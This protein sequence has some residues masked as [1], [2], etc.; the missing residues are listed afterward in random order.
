MSVWQIINEELMIMD[1]RPK[2]NARANMMAGKGYERG[3]QYRSVF[4]ALPT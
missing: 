1:C 3:E 2:V 4:I